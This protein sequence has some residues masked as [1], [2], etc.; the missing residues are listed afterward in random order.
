[1][2]HGLFHVMSIIALVYFVVLN[3]TYLV[4]TGV[5]WRGITQHRRER[6]YAALEEAFASPLTP[7]ISI[8]LPAYN[9]EAGIVN[10]RRRAAGG[11]R[12]LAS[13]EAHRRR[14]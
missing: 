9:E 14:S 12:P 13:S 10:R 4:F 6:R 1:M 8:L 2:I 7:P 11:G 5:A 3:G